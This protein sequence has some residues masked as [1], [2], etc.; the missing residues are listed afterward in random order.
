MESCSSPAERLSLSTHPRDGA[1]I[2][3]ARGD[4]DLTTMNLLDDCLTRARDS[5]EHIIVE[6][7]AIEYIDC[8]CLTVIAVHCKALTA[9]G[10]TLT[11]TSLRPLPARMVQIAGL[12]PM[13]ASYDSADHA[14]DRS[15]G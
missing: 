5:Y 2:I 10:G 6:S 4:F 8:A 12:A 13:L 9:Q 7:A 14:L 11:L 15:R 1:L 3:T